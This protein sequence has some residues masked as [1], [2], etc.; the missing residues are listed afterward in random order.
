MHVASLLGK[1]HGVDDRAYL[2]PSTLGE[3]TAAVL[4]KWLALSP[5]RIT[6]LHQQ[7]VV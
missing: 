5:A 1:L 6:R 2:A 4:Q 7:G 3:H